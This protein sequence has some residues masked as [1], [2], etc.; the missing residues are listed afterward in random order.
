LTSVVASVCNH[1]EPGAA[2]TAPSGLPVPDRWTA[3]LVA[4]WDW[5]EADTGTLS[6]AVAVPVAY[7]DA[8]A[9]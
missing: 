1:V 2:V 6:R 7:D 9:V 4:M 3:P 5:P 8:S